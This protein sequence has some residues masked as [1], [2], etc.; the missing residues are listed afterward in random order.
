MFYL[1]W[2]FK[3]VFYFAG[4]FKDING[5]YDVAFYIGGM[6]VLIGTLI[7]FVNNIVHCIRTRQDTKRINRINN[8]KFVTSIKS[9][10]TNINFRSCR[11]ST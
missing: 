2:L 5:N 6:G 9:T 3:V 4:L 8:L 7:L 11:H 1:S 10:K